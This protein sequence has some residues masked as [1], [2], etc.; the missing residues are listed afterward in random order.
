[1]QCDRV[2]VLKLINTGDRTVKKAQRS[3]SLTAN[4]PAAP[5]TSDRDMLAFPSYRLFP[6]QDCRLVSVSQKIF[7]NSDR[8]YQKLEIGRFLWPTLPTTQKH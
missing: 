8:S 2:E 6:V 3:T 7:A 5:K 4:L 1:M